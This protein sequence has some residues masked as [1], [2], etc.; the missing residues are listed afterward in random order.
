MSF[1]RQF[2]CSVLDNNHRNGRQHQFWNLHWRICQPCNNFVCVICVDS[3]ITECPVWIASKAPLLP[4]SF[5]SPTRILSG[6]FLM[7][8]PEIKHCH[9]SLSFRI[10]KPCNH[11]NPVQKLWQLDFSCVFYAYYSLVRRKE[12]CNNIK[13]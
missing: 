2:S 4:F 13:H 12:I 5:L 6:S 3:R 9:L 7:N 1:L 8:L 11:R 10:W